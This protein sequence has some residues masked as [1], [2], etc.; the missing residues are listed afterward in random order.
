MSCNTC[1]CNPCNCYPSI[2]SQWNTCPPTFT[3][4]CPPIPCPPVIPDPCACMQFIRV[5]TNQADFFAMPATVKTLIPAP[6]AGKMIVPINI[7][8]I[9]TVNNPV[10][11]YKDILTVTP[12]LIISLGNYAMHSDSSILGAIASQTTFYI[13]STATLAGIFDNQPLTLTTSTQS[14]VGDSNLYSYIFYS[15]VAL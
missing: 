4:S 3:Q 15:I 9:L 1:N 2:P 11:P 5:L 14:V 12:T 13:Q 10:V 7:F 8:N 6:G